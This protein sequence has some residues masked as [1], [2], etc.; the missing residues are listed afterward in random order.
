MSQYISPD[1]LLRSAQN[2]AT[3]EQKLA[4]AQEARKMLSHPIHISNNYIIPNNYNN[5]NQIQYN[6]AGGPQ[7]SINNTQISFYGL[8][9]GPPSSGVSPNARMR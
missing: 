3:Q 8:G 5:Y 9:H 6:I 7:N 1:K 2:A 4:L